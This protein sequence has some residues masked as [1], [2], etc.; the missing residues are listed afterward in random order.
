MSEDKPHTSPLR[1]TR[2]IQ[3]AHA[4]APD[5]FADPR[6]I[7]LPPSPNKTDLRR[8]PTKSSTTLSR[9]PTTTREL[10]PPPAPLDEILSSLQSA[11]RAAQ[12]SI[13]T[14]E[15]LMLRDLPEEVVQS[16]IISR[17]IQELE[18]KNERASWEIT[19]AQ[20][21]IANLQSEL[22]HDRDEN[23][24]AAKQSQEV[25]AYLEKRLSESQSSRT[26]LSLEVNRLRELVVSKEAE[27]LGERE[28]LLERELNSQAE[29]EGYAAAVNRAEGRTKDV[30]VVLQA[31]RRE[32]EE[33]LFT[34]R[35]LREEGVRLS[36]AVDGLEGELRDTRKS[37]G[38][39][40]GGWV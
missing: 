38:R 24:T 35:A 13:I 7:P 12:S 14:I 27:V 5:P 33:C 4:P 26:D 30:E 9:C 11:H 25:I 32:L 39:K 18:D 1:P 3:G 22:A 21:T 37:G 15:R 28:K 36:R 34:V 29:M 31:T 6:R 19:D 23:Q 8:S 2:R 10:P 20:Q 16:A 40:G 17:R